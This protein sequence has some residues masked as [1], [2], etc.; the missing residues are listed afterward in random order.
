MAKN[1]SNGK[2]ESGK[3]GADKNT[4]TGEAADNRNFVA[5]LVEGLRRVWHAHGLPDRELAEIEARA[6][7]IAPTPPTPP[8]PPKLD[9][10]VPGLRC[11]VCGSLEHHHRPAAMLLERLPAP[12]SVGGKVECL[13][14]ACRDCGASFKD[15]AFFPEGVVR[16]RVAT[17]CPACHT[18]LLM[19]RITPASVEVYATPGEWEGRKF[20]DH[21]LRC[22]WQGCGHEYVAREY[23]KDEDG[24]LLEGGR[25]KRVM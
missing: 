1:G 20:I 4:R 6:K 15:E 19:D 23:I 14:A 21:R 7:G 12:D 18:R 25:P 13:R 22:R 10:S 24:P 9:E 11:P 3:G 5:A 2:K 16:F 8:Q 17:G